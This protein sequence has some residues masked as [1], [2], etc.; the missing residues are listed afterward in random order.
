MKQTDQFKE[1]AKKAY[2]NYHEDGVL[3]LIMGASCLGIAAFFGTGNIVFNMFT[4]MPILFF[5]PLKNRITFPRIGYVKFDTRRGRPAKLILL[6]SVTI[7]LGLFVLG[8]VFFLNTGRVDPAVRSWIG[9]HLILILGLIFALIL[10]MVA[11]TTSIRRLYLYAGLAA[12]SFV[13]SFLLEL[14]EFAGFLAIGVVV[15]VSGIVQVVR[16]VRKYPVPAEE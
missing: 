9:E 13:T 16:F 8:T 10:T 14:P 11:F 6:M 7:V 15:F 1:L 3:D 4:W 2:L 12:V 5:M